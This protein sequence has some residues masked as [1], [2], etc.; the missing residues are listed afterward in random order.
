MSRAAIIN[1]SGGLL[2]PLLQLI[3]SNVGLV[4][5]IKVGGN[6]HTSQPTPAPMD[7]LAMLYGHLC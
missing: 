7:T 6:G 5:G 2:S 4:A 3:K 1:Q